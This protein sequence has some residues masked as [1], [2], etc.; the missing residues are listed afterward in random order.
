MTHGAEATLSAFTPALV[1]VSR[2][3]LA[4]SRHFLQ[5]HVRRGDARDHTIA[6][7]Y[8]VRGNPE[9]TVSTP[10]TWERRRPRPH[11]AAGVGGAGRGGGR[12][13]AH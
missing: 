8:S 10:I 7:A 11:A 9:G 12:R 2:M 5:I 6:A 13:A 3:V 4:E 1:R